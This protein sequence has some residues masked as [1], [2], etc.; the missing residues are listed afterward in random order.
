MFLSQHTEAMESLFV[1]THQ[2]DLTASR[3]MD[4][5]TIERS[6]PGSNRRELEQDTIYCFE[7]FLN[8]CE[9]RFNDDSQTM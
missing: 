4:L 1:A 7:A 3:I 2:E 9:R 5:Y 8:Y 6:E